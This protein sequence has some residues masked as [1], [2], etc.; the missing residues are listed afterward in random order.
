MQI[1]PWESRPPPHEYLVG[2]PPAPAPLGLSKNPI[3]ANQVFSRGS[4]L[5]RTALELRSVYTRILSARV[6]VARF[7][8]L[9]LRD[10]TFL[11]SI[12][13][14]KIKFARRVR[15]YSEVSEFLCDK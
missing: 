9:A 14:G 4:L 10:S 5:V 2:P 13:R 1:G 8:T 6:D 12:L 11:Q 3:K 7:A 15:R